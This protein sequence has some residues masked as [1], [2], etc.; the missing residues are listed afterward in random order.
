MEKDT[1]LNVTIPV[2]MISKSKRG[3]SQQVYGRKQEW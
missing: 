3:C 2:L 1:T